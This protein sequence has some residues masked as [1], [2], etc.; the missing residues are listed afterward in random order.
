MPKKRHS[1]KWFNDPGSFLNKAAALG[2]AAMVGQWMRSMDIQAVYY[3]RSVDPAL[4]EFRGPIAVAVWHEYILPILYL[5]GR[6]NTSILT[7]RHTDAN[8]L[9]E[10]LRHFG[11]GHV[12]GSTARGGSQ[13]L[14]ELLELCR[15]QNLGTAGDGPRGP[16]RQMAPGLAYLSS[17]LQIPMAPYAVG[18]DRPY[19][20]G[21]WDRF[22][23]PR[24]GSRVRI[25]FGP[26]V[27]V[28]PN[29]D[30]TELEVYRLRMEKLLEEL[31][32]EAEQWAE[33]GARHP[34]QVPLYRRPAHFAFRRHLQANPGGELGVAPLMVRRVRRAA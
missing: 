15:T 17:K 4:P 22:A 31:T 2:A 24:W 10:V 8:I 30:R 27:Q 18:F 19:R 34:N 9:T 5:R 14:L 7:S 32:H 1:K 3:D 28:P 26:R 29:A 21:T 12:R 13:A 23:I 20:M 6:S 25:I 33:S 11:Y 16:R